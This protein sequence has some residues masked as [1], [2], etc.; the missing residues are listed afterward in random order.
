MIKIANINIV[1]NQLIKQVLLQANETN[2]FPNK[3]WQ[4]RPR[5]MMTMT[6]MMT[7][8]TMKAMMTMMAMKKWVKGEAS[9]SWEP[10]AEE[11]QKEIEQVTIIIIID[12]KLRFYLQNI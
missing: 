4:G 2:V 11:W 5:Y 1:I 3:F 8:M 6:M 10:L 7:M 12:V 9:D